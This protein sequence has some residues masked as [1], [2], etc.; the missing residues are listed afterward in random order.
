LDAIAK[1]GDPAL[2]VAISKLCD[3]A[4]AKPDGHKKRDVGRGNVVLNDLFVYEID[5]ERDLVYVKFF[6]G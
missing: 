5:S 1:S 3:P 6:L 4:Y 2:A